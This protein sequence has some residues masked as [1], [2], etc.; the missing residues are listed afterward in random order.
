MALEQLSAE[1][2]NP[3]W[4]GLVTST[5]PVPAVFDTTETCKLSRGK[6]QS[7]LKT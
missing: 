3:G 5:A 6:S 4:L 2:I 7:R 1:L